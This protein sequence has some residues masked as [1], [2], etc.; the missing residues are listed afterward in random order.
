APLRFRLGLLGI[1]HARKVRVDVAPAVDLLRVVLPPWDPLDVVYL[2]A[3]PAL[4]AIDRSPIRAV[5]ARDDAYL[6]ELLHLAALQGERS[7]I[8]VAGL[9]AFDARRIGRDPTPL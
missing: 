5:E 3:A 9:R 6:S 4:P 8:E 2:L 1:N 7:G